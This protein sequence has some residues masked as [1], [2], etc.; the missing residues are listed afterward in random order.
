[1]CLCR[2]VCEHLNK[3]FLSTRSYKL[4]YSIHL[5]WVLQE[6]HY[7]LNQYCLVGN[8]YLYSKAWKPNPML[9]PRSACKDFIHKSHN[10][11]ARKIGTSKLHSYNLHKV[12]STCEFLWLQDCNQ[13][14]PPSVKSFYQKWRKVFWTL[15]HFAVVN[16]NSKESLW[17]W[18]APQVKLDEIYTI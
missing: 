13:K 11:G 17:S 8:S 7:F 6:L 4:I 16:C 18:F 15:L 2:S 14:F 10:W 12:N 9:L 5:I 3:H 1:M